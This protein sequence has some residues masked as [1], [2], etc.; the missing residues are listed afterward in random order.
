MVTL[1]IET[2]E[3]DVPGFIRGH[4]ERAWQILQEIAVAYQDL[5]APSSAKL[6]NLPLEIIE[7]IEVLCVTLE[8]SSDKLVYRINKQSNT[9]EACLDQLKKA[10]EN[11]DYNPGIAK[12]LKTTKMCIN[13]INELA[14]SRDIDSYY[15]LYACYRT[16]ERNA[17][18]VTQAS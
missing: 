16:L 9:G 11:H 14:G 7:K 5:H 13:Y 15:H 3:D 6:Y 1:I 10:I 8:Y 17:G 18:E 4:V 12:S 2:N